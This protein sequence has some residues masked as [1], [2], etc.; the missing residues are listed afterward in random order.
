MSAGSKIPTGLSRP[1]GV[2]KSFD[3]RSHRHGGWLRSVLEQPF[4]PG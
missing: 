1:S 4:V 3:G 2:G